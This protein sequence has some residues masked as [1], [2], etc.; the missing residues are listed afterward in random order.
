MNAVIP[1]SPTVKFKEVLDK[2]VE[3]KNVYEVNST[4]MKKRDEEIEAL[5]YELTACKQQ[6]ASVEL[7]LRD[8]KQVLETEKKSKRI[9][10]NLYHK[11][12]EELETAER[13]IQAKSDR[14]TELEDIFS[15]TQEELKHANSTIQDK[16]DQIKELEGLFF[17]TLKELE[18]VEEESKEKSDRLELL[19]SLE[20]GS[21][22][23]N[24]RIGCNDNEALYQL[25][26]SDSNLALTPALSP[27]PEENIDE[28]PD[29]YDQWLVALSTKIC[30]L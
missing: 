24:G 14:F 6:V 12:Q 22:D 7:E 15:K 29:Y 16:S 21:D 5:R 13:T 27:I 11:S 30:H 2:L 20:F 23:V 8:T 10:K 4:L 17:K 1:S 28:I 25:N 3:L 9:L 19:M 26:Q 18:K